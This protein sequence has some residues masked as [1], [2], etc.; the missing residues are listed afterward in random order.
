MDLKLEQLMEIEKE[1]SADGKKWKE[2]LKTHLIGSTNVK[3]Q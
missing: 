1:F 3:V 2:T